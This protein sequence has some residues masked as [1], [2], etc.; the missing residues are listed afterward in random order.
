MVTSNTKVSSGMD[1][2]LKCI[3]YGIAEHFVY[4]KSKLTPIKPI[5]QFLLMCRFVLVH[6]S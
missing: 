4:T 1:Q 6:A 5:L 2:N 3:K